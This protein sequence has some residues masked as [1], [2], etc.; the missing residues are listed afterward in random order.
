VAIKLYQKQLFRETTK[1]TLKMPKKINEDAAEAKKG[2]V[3]EEMG[4]KKKDTK[5][6]KKGKG[7]GK[8]K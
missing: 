3:A 7:G 2:K 8:K 4:G 5:E 1:A 6:T